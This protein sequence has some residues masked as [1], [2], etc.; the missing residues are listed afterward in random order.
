MAEISVDEVSGISIDEDSNP[1]VDEDSGISVDEDSRDLYM[2]LVQGKSE[3][4][5]EL[6]KNSPDGPF[7]VVTIHNDT[8]LHVAASCKQVDLVHE[9]LRRV[10][11]D[12]RDKLRLQNKVGNTILHE[13][14]TSDKLV[15]AAK[16]MLNKAPKLLNIRNNFGVTP[17]YRSVVFG[18]MD[19]FKFLDAITRQKQTTDQEGDL[20]ADPEVYYHRK[21][22]TTVL[23]TA[24]VIGSFDLAL[25]IATRYK[26]LVDEQDRDG[27]TA[28]QL[29]AC[30]SL[31]F[32]SRGGG[33]FLE[34]LLCSQS[35][36]IL[37][38][39]FS[40]VLTEEM[41]TAAGEEDRIGCFSAESTEDITQTKAGCWRVP[42]WE[43]IQ[44]ER[45]TYEWAVKLAK[46]LIKEDRSWIKTKAVET[47]ERQKLH[48]YGIKDSSSAPSEKKKNEQKPEPSTVIA[49]TP[50][51][52]ATKNGCLE[53]VKEI[54]RVYP[55]A[56]E[57]IDHQGRTIL[58][59]AIKY[60]QMEVLDLV[61]QMGLLVKRLER[62]VDEKSNTI[63]HM[64][65]EKTED[66]IVPEL[67][68]PAF[69]LQENLLL[70]ERV[71]DICPGSLL[72]TLN[73]DK[74]TAQKL[75]EEE[76][77][78]LRK[79]AKEWL[80]RTAEHCSL[81]AV[82]IATV[83]FAAA[84]TIPG[85]PNQSTGFPILL[86][87]PFFFVFTLTD[88]LSLTFALTSVIFFLRILT[89]PFRLKDFKQ[90]LPQILMLGVTLL[91]LSVSMMMFAF[92]AT[93]ILMI[94]RREEWT[95]VA[96]YTASLLPVTIFALSYLPLY[97]S[98]M[99]TFNYSLKK[100]A[101][102]FPRFTGYP[103]KSEPKKLET[104]NYPPKP[105]ASP[106]IV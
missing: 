85:G 7:Q 10:S 40:G 19:M 94:N 55:W 42:Y 68:S 37:A 26:Y 15:Q 93:V 23:H 79:K 13:V 89:S 18:K 38:A 24:V 1:A 87:R 57:H 28:L 95:K 103:H 17:L 62:K 39:S 75:F 78:P 59:V 32:K 34:R 52:L 99:K 91:I 6:C 20:E 14:S 46:F 102:I 81:V 47:R 67:Q 84:Y 31:A 61:E 98:L 53:I 9:L 8:V 101:M 49:E 104:S 33:G 11:N 21:N 56:V 16:E 45:E 48:H 25:F 63:L 66:R 72:N 64:V 71:W 73:K 2:A 100:V 60:R 88:V 12:Q 76:T 5:L 97:L 58:H 50:L 44:E 36:N 105:Q 43:T 51:F 96:L 83:A 54:L 106:Y 27:M 3:K 22:K 74:K 4:V 70:Y 35:K 41:S 30:N 69:E 29:L 77:E 86:N 80:Q 65:G 92:A 82:L 90:S